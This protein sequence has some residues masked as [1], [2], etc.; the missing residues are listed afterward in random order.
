MG[1]YECTVCGYVYDEAKGIPE[2]SIGPGTAWADVPEDW[3]CPLCGA[4]KAEFKKQGESN[5]ILKKKPVSVVE[6]SGDMKDLSPLE[7][8]ALCSNL[9]RGCKMQYKPEAAALFGEVAAYFKGAASPAKDPDID[10]LIS[11]LEKDLEEGFPNANAVASEAKD[12]G[13]MRALVWSEKVTRILK[14]LL[15]RYQKEGEAM[16]ENA[17]I[18]VCTICGFVYIG[19]I[20]P[21]ICPV[22]KV[23]NWKFEKVEGR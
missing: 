18:N 16:L 14:S 11:L 21:E 13:A 23:P 2:A 17:D 20:P 12:R 5:G 7:A 9:A 4:T 15:V 6:A 10:K 3:V 1:K 8:S 19:D 22:C